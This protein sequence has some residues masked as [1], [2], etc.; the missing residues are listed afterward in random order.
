MEGAVINAQ[1]LTEK[2][3]SE[4]AVS[5]GTFL[6][7]PL[8]AGY[9]MAKNYR[10]FHES[11]NG[12]KCWLYAALATSMFFGA[13]LFIPGLEKLPRLTWPLVETAL[14]SFLVHRL[15]DK[16]IESHLSAG[17]QTYCWGRTIAVA[18]IG[19]A[20]TV[21][22][23]FIVLLFKATSVTVTHPKTYGP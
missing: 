5:V 16:K 19:C 20:V 23:L 9:M 3:Y 14:A 12:R 2:I 10:A 7:G 13:L 1:A 11:G 17:G 4:K 22:F 6:G 8:V 21:I 15:Q 18:L